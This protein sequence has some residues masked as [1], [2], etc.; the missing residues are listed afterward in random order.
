MM[1]A[2]EGFIYEQKP[3]SVTRYVV[4]WEGWSLVRM[5]VRQGF[6]CTIHSGLY[7]LA[8][9]SARAC[10]RERACVRV[11]ACVYACVRA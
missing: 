1:V 6:Y 7:M 11:R 5:V 8:G 10:V 3:L 2:R 4:V 9:A